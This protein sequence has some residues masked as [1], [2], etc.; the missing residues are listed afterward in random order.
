MQIGVVQGQATATIKHASFTGW[1]LLLVQNV[2]VDGQPDGEPILVLDPLGA[3]VGSKVIVC[4]DGAEARRLVGNR[5]SP[6]R[7][8]VM[9]LCDS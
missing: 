9:G 5:N 3:H 4:N 7:W 1:K 2:G 6:A 8:F